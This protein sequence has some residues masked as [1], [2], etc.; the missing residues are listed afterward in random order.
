MQFSKMVC[1]RCDHYRQCPPKTRIYINYC[2]SKKDRVEEDIRKA[3][4]DCD[5]RRGHT[6][7]LRLAPLLQ[8]A[9]NA[10]A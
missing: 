4:A 2:G 8:G 6:R 5:S 1:Q 3:I 9:G 10:A 7:M